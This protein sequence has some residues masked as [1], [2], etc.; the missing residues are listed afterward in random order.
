MYVTKR[1]I[2]ILL[3]ALLCAPALPAQDR[4]APSQANNPT[5]QDGVVIIIQQEQVRFTTQKAVQMMQLQVFN[6]SGETIFDSGPVSAGEINWA[7]QNANG[8]EFK[9]G[10]YAY[11]FSIQE[12]G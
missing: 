4:K 7:F 8:E 6:P 1:L 5:A 9:S 11:T 3:C 10:L 2:A 12:S